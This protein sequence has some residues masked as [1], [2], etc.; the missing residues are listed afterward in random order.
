MSFSI[1]H[2]LFY[3]FFC[4][5]SVAL[6]TFC[7]D[8]NNNSVQD[9]HTAGTT[10]A[11]TATQDTTTTEPNYRL[12]PSEITAG[13]PFSFEMT[14]D[15]PYLLSL[16]NCGANTLLL[17]G[18]WPDAKSATTHI[19]GQDGVKL[20][21]LAIVDTSGSPTITTNCQLK[22]TVNRGKAG[23]K[24]TLMPLTIKAG[25]ITLSNAKM[26]A[27]NIELE[28]NGVP[29][30]EFSIFV[31]G[32]KETSTPSGVSL[33]E[34]RFVALSMPL[35]KSVQDGKLASNVELYVPPPHSPPIPTQK[36]SGFETG[37]YLISV[38]SYRARG[39]DP[40]SVEFLH[41]SAIKA[42]KD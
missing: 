29:S 41:I 31:V 21:N 18:T 39:F 32:K 10:P 38:V 14:S 24:S 1:K 22:A 25:T 30:N 17:Q 34:Y 23:E 2:S 6:L 40:N 27:K 5:S 28:A 3:V 33:T 37:D 16:D 9:D 36:I 26:L 11:P 35:T 7:G 19:E 4:L 42:S 8:S 13:L 15:N 20:N 12:T